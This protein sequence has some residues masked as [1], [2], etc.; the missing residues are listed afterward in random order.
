M[1][2]D[3]VC[4]NTG[5]IIVGWNMIRRIENGGGDDVESILLLLS[6]AVDCSQNKYGYVPTAIAQTI[7]DANDRNWIWDG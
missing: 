1:Y 2:N 3:I 5:K 7:K 6:S 4:T